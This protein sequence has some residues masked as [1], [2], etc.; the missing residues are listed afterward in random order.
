M[1]SRIGQTRA[2]ANAIRERVISLWLS[3][4]YRTKEIARIVDRD[5]S[6]VLAI[7]K[8]RFGPEVQVT[9]RLKAR[10]ETMLQLAIDGES[11]KTLAA[12]FHL[13][14]QHVGD[15]IREDLLIMPNAAA[16]L[17][18]NKEI[19]ERWRSGESADQL[20]QI[21][22]VGR[23]RILRIVKPIRDQM[24][25]DPPRCAYCRKPL[26]VERQVAGK[27]CCRQQCERHLARRVANQRAKAIIQ[28]NGKGSV[29]ETVALET[30]ARRSGLQ[31]TRSRALQMIEQRN[32]MIEQRK[33][34]RFGRLRKY[35]YFDRDRSLC[36]RWSIDLVD[37]DGLEV[38]GRVFEKC[39]R[40]E[41]RLQKRGKRP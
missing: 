14:E 18:R 17:A 39:A 7:L 1:A 29:P 40:C 36:S 19:Q 28:D 21:F 5:P 8:A 41:R 31:S 27:K 37:G 30:P 16:R 33:W 38:G 26:T 4:R 23:D 34:A 3:G 25:V 20:A 35:H 10:N 24:K 11:T 13:T 12:M 6:R 22:K 9:K 2:N 32:R 15:I